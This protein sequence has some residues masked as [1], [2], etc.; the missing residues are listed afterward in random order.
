MSLIV[1]IDKSSES[2]C[3]A[4]GHPSDCPE[5]VPGQVIEENSHNVTITNANGDTKQVATVD[6]ANMDWDPHSHDYDA[7]NKCHD[8]EP[9]TLDPNNNGLFP[10]VTINGS[11]VYKENTNVQTDPKTGEAINFTGSGINNSIEGI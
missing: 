9:H 8:D 5:P 10:S 3:E 6:S 11:P 2:S 1:T 4:T 7:I